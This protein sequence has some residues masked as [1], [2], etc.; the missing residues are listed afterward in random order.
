MEGDT[1]RLTIAAANS[2]FYP[3]PPGGGRPIISAAITERDYFY[4]RPPGGGRLAIV[5]HLLFPFWIS[6]HA[7]RVEGD[8]GPQRRRVLG[9][10]SIHALRVEGDARMIASS[11]W[12]FGFLSTPSGWRATKAPAELAGRDRNF[13][14][15]PPGG[16]RP[17][18]SSVV[19]SPL[20]FL[21]TPSGW[22]ATSAKVVSNI[23]WIQISIH[24]LRVEGDRTC[25]AST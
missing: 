14:P 20:I 12:S 3:R 22:R 1:P 9:R 13:Y 25:A 7:L 11:R 24:A 4:P 8:R 10:I 5:A 6:I 19:R 23:H 2:D 17:S 21:S 15:R 16:G 18:V